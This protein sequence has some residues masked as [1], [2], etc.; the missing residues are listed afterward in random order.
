AWAQLIGIVLVS[1]LVL[2]ALLMAPVWVGKKLFCKNY[3]PGPLSVR[4][5]PLA[6][7]ILL[8]VFDLLL[9]YGFR[10]VFLFSY[11]DDLDLGAPNFLTVSIM[12]ASIAFPLAAGMGLYVAWRSR[13]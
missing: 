8:V 3:N 1:L 4:F 12:L 5:W 10:G 6:S 9:A 2:S 7:A 13:N 11:F